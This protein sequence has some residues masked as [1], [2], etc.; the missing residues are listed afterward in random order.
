M[1]DLGGRVAVVTGGGSGIGRGICLAAAEQGMHVV[2]TDI[3]G[4]AAEETAALVRD[5]GVQSLGVAADVSN[6][7]SV[8]ALA[9]AAYGEFGAVDVLFNNAGVLVFGPTAEMPASDLDW[10]LAVN[11]YG[12]LNG[13]QVFVPRMRE[14]EPDEDGTR[15]QIVNTSSM[16]GLVAGR[17]GGNLGGYVASKFAVVGMTESLRLELAPE[18]IDVTLFCPGATHT[19][20]GEAQRNRQEAYG[21]ARE[22]PEPIIAQRAAPRDPSRSPDARRDP[23][24]V[25]RAVL[26]GVRERRAYILTHTETRPVVARRFEHI[27][28]GYDQAERSAG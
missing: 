11:L 9:D 16:S 6:P 13:I 25:G 21:P 23:L 20:I 15:A 14:Q 12:V 24:V 26:E 17:G 19:R 28:E 10:M 18:G 4:D 27:A 3:E 22:I 1:R 5:H 8:E 2:V 7:A